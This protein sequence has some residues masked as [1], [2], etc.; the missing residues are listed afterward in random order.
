MT[1]S[2]AE[3]SIR[4]VD[5]AWFTWAVFAPGLACH[6]GEGHGASR[7]DALYRAVDS[8]RAVEPQP[9]G[10]VTVYSTTGDVARSPLWAVPRYELLSWRPATESPVAP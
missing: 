3:I 8:V 6:A 5:D 7:T 1:K 10:E 2:V 4:Q 9:V